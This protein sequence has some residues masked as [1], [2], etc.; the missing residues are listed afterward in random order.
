[1]PVF[2]IAWRTAATTLMSRSASTPIL[3]LVV[4]MPSAITSAASHPDATAARDERGRADRSTA[5]TTPTTYD[6]Q[7][8]PPCKAS[9]PR[10][11]TLLAGRLPAAPAVAA[12]RAGLLTLRS[13]HRRKQT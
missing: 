7:C 4:V 2:P 8:P 9:A 13:Q 1:M 3:T 11:R 12:R 5:G 6:R 10:R